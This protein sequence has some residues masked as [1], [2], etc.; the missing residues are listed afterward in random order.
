MDGWDE[1]DTIL[2]NRNP[3]TALDSV[4]SLDFDNDYALSL[5][6]DHHILGSNKNKK[7]GFVEEHDLS[8]NS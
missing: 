7:H 4:L 6:T 8:C 5:Q 1:Y 2:L 3:D